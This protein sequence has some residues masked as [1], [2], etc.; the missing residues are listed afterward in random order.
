MTGRQIIQ[1]AAYAVFQ[2]GIVASLIFFLIRL[3]PGDP[4]RA[5]LG[6]DATEKQVAQMRQTMHLD[7]SLGQQFGIYW[8]QLVHGDLGKSLISG[9][10]IGPDLLIRFVN[11]IELIGLATVVG[12]IGGVLVGRFAAR[13]A[14]KLPDSIA[15]SAAVFGLSLPV[16]VT[17]TL[18]LLVFSVVIPVLPPERYVPLLQEPSTHLRTVILPVLSLS[19]GLGA[20]V[21]RMTRSA[22]LETLSQDYVRTARAKGVVEKIVI[23]RHSLVPALVPVISVVGVELAT[24]IG[25]T[26]LVEQ[27][28]GW[29]GLSSMLIEAVKSRD[30][31]VVEAVLL[32]TSVF[33]ITVNFI[34]DIGVHIINP[35]AEETA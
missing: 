19:A 26:V 12:S 14:G 34:V 9:R 33:V 25:S 16:F 4:A 21:T 32:V 13:R 6:E 31:P 22:M 23:R 5:V 30:Y 18:L 27:I 15:T 24:L 17:G 10:A 35:Q 11:S 1:R 2:I 29:P 8:S 7:D 20:V 28:F 3:V